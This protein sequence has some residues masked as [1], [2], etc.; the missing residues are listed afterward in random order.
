MS[1]WLASLVLWSLL[2]A[3][4]CSHRP[5]R[6]GVNLFIPGDCRAEVR[7][8]NC[9]VKTDPPLC[10]SSKVRYAKGC[11]QIELPKP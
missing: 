5:V 11:A 3:P 2:T 1:P 8:L 7:M 4:A 10:Q 6:T 9:N